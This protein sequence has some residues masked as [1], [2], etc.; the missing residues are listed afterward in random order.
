M[1]GYRQDLRLNS[2]NSENT[3]TLTG[4]IIFGDK[5]REFL[6]RHISGYRALGGAKKL[7][8]LIVELASLSVVNPTSD[9]ANE[10]TE[11]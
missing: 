11:C 10:L 9:N 7:G 4:K 6:W 8:D 2:E 1:K 3:L 5:S